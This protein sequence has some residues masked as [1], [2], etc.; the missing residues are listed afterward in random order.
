MNDFYS[1]TPAFLTSFAV[2]VTLF[3]CYEVVFGIL[4]GLCH[5]FQENW[6]VVY[7]DNV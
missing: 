4:V 7:G 3:P 5:A 2:T 6:V 1:D